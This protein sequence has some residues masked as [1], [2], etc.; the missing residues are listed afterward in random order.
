MAVRGDEV[1]KNGPLTLGQ[2][3]RA[4]SDPELV[5]ELDALAAQEYGANPF[6]WLEDRE[7]QELRFHALRHQVEQKFMGLLLKGALVMTGFDPRNPLD[8][9]PVRI[10]PIR[11]PGSRIDFSKSTVTRD[12]ITLTVVTVTL[13]DNTAPVSSPVGPAAAIII[14][15]RLVLRVG[16]KSISLDGIERSPPGR[17]FQLLHVMARAHVAGHP[18]QPRS[19]IHSAIFSS[20]SPEETTTKLISELRS[21]FQH[22]FGI[23]KDGGGLISLRHGV[24]YEILLPPGAVLIDE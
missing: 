24:G 17:L 6:F 5:A 9:P 7:E 20:A 21:F 18:C 16:L 10:P 2:A 14:E 4:C 19:E 23:A 22:Q 15:P 11:L 8:S 1:F 12:G 13:P 3:L